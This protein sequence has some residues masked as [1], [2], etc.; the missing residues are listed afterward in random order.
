MPQSQESVE[1][2]VPFCRRTS[3]EAL[4]G[5]KFQ[6]IKCRRKGQKTK[7]WAGS[8]EGEKSFVVCLDR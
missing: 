7:N 1:E 5:K 6:S 3:K 8:D 4:N 2:S